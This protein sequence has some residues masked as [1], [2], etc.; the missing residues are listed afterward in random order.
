LSWFFSPLKQLHYGVILADPPW[1]YE[2]RSTKGQEKSPS[3]HYKT[4]SFDEIAY[5]PV[6]M[7]AADDSMLVLWTSA[8]HL[9]ESIEIMEDWGFDFVTAGAWAKQSKT[10]E[11]WAFGTGFVYRSAAEFY[12]VGK[13][14]NPR[15]AV[16]NIRNL[17]IAPVREHSRKPDEMHEQIERMF[18][19]VPRCE[20]FGRQRRPGWDVFGDE[21]GKFNADTDVGVSRR[22]AHADPRRAGCAELRD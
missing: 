17:I 8:P 19:D 21:A 11:K 5:L 18:P 12:L 16:K 13:I 1:R 2:T 22:V 7:L 6:H 14:G 20:L 9:K 15:I 4:M 3:R 10:G